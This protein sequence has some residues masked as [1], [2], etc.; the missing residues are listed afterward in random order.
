MRKKRV[1]GI[2]SPL[3]L[4]PLIGVVV[5][6]GATVTSEG[7]AKIISAVREDVVSVLGYTQ[8]ILTPDQDPLAKEE[9]NSSAIDERLKTAKFDKGDFHLVFNLSGKSIS[10]I[11]LKETKLEWYVDSIQKSHSYV[12]ENPAGA[13]YKV[14]IKIFKSSAK[15]SVLTYLIR[16]NDYTPYN[17]TP[18][19]AQTD[20]EAVRDILDQNIRTIKS[21]VL[22]SEK[23]NEY[24]GKEVLLGDAYSKLGI[25]FDELEGMQLRDTKVALII[26]PDLTSGSKETQF[27]WSDKATAKYIIS[28]RVS[29]TNAPLTVGQKPGYTKWMYSSIV[30]KDISEMEYFRLKTNQLTNIVNEDVYFTNHMRKNDLFPSDFATVGGTL[31]AT[32][33]G[34][35]LSTSF[36]DTQYKFMVSKIDDKRGSIILDATI[37]STNNAADKKMFS[38][39]VTGFKTQE[40]QIRMA[41]DRLSTLI[42]NNVFTSAKKSIDLDSLVSNDPD[43]YDLNF[44][45]FLT[46]TGLT[47]QGFNSI[48][49][50]DYLKINSDETKG[51]DLNF[52][53]TA[54]DDALLTAGKKYKVN[55]HFSWKKSSDLPDQ[56]VNETHVENYSW[57]IHSSDAK[58]DSS[59]YNDNSIKL[60][61]AKK[62][63]YSKLSSKWYHEINSDY[64]PSQIRSTENEKVY[65]PHDVNFPFTRKELESDVFKGVSVTIHEIEGG[66]IDSLGYL[67]VNVEL[68]IGGVK[69][70]FVMTI[71]GYRTSI[72]NIRSSQFEVDTIAKLLK[73]HDGSNS[74]IIFTEDNRVHK[75]LS[76]KIFDEWGAN[77]S[78][79]REI[80]GKVMTSIDP[81]ISSSIAWSDWSVE[82]GLTIQFKISKNGYSAFSNIFNV[83]VKG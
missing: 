52:K 63:I 39:T 48:Y 10:G 61:N 54:V 46:K 33:L 51:I 75:T 30:Y 19:S 2:V 14:N 47:V 36:K 83:R 34:I 27:D 73:L 45:D 59:N 74:N 80:L 62:L 23:I 29:K 56:N 49:F 50:A 15:P 71:K 31:T 17:N 77:D 37:S 55:A 6:C 26:S 3:M 81:S 64:L 5:S 66:Q 78:L 9:G 35:D 32:E 58:L 53:I 8:S 65:S 40:A 72:E 12:D 57:Y 82:N 16:S 7:Y 68:S 11:D 67:Q 44:S 41:V 22:N 43:K 18:E 24:I 21:S 28:Y 25:K 1:L 79:K 69:T 42:E 70:F 13:E 4:S 38:F 60:E 20:V 76:P